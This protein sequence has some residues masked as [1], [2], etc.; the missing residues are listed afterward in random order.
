MPSRHLLLLQGFYL[1][2]INTFRELAATF[3]GYSRACWKLAPTARFKKNRLWPKLSKSRLYQSRD[4]KLLLIRVNCFN[5]LFNFQFY[6]CFFISMRVCVCTIKSCISY[7]FFL[8]ILGEQ[9]KASTSLTTEHLP[10]STMV[11]FIYLREQYHNI[12]PQNRCLTR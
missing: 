1:F 6:S 4:G 2:H 12:T 8:I 7:F 11:F 10:W 5:I 9:F 3:T